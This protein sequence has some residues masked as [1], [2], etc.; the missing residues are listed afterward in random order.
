MSEETKEQQIH[1][2]QGPVGHPGGH[3]HGQ[4]GAEGTHGEGLSK[5][6][7]TAEGWHSQHM[8]FRIDFNAWKKWSSEDKAAAKAELKAYIA[9]LEAEHVAEKSSYAFYSINGQKGD[10]LL[11]LL[12]PTLEDI[13][14]WEL[15]FRKLKIAEVLEYTFSYTSVTELSNYLKNNLASP[16]VHKKLYPHIPKDKYIC[17]YNMSKK[18]E[19]GEN[20][21]ILPMEERGK[22]MRAHGQL[23]RTYLD[24]LSE[25]TTGGCG[26]DMWEWGI[27][28]MGN[29]DIQFKKIVYDMRF[30]EASARFGI[31]S[32]F[33]VGTI[34]DDTLLETTFD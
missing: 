11:W 27:T 28:L 23:G 15:R 9:D 25:Y 34:M 32:D 13:Y 14:V 29:D 17:F 20:W 33:Y 1:G 3:P 16:E 10:I 2:G 21:F 24:V 12:Q 26:L 22:M 7:R 19:H 18:R 5:A 4:V 6:V 8:I 31:F 30:E